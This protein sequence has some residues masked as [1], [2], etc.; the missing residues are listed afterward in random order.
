MS[1][2]V[3]APAE[4]SNDGHIQV[5]YGWQP[6]DYQMGAWAHFER[7]KAGARGVCVW[8]RRAGKDLFGVNLVAVKSTER[9]GLYWHLFPTYNQGRKIAWDGFTKTGRRFISHFPPALVESINNTEMRINL[10]TG[11]QYQVVGTEDP[12]RLVGANPVGCIFSEYSLQ[13][14]RAWDIIRPILAENEG[15]ALFIYTARGKNHGF[16]M[17]EGARK[18]IERDRAA[19]KESKWYAEVL[20]AGSGP[21]DT[22]RRD[23][24]PVISDE[25]IQEE[26]DAG[27]PEEL[28]AQEFKCSFEAPIVG[29]YYATQMARALEENRIGKV[30]WE[31]Q[32]KVNTAWDLGMGDAMSIVFFQEYGLETRIIDYYESSGEGL[33]HYIKVLRERDYVYGEHIAPWDIEVRELGTGKSRLEVA[34]SL[35]LN[36]RV[37]KQSSVSDGIEMVRNLI[38]TCWFDADKCDRLV[39][40]LRGYRKEYDEVRKVFKNNPLHDWTSHP[41]DAFRYLAMGRRKRPKNREKPQEAADSSYD[42]HSI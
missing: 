8:H 16:T 41:A 22:K 36:F 28:I 18:I 27:M 32:L 10:K 14:P 23:G 4:V 13:D 40:A 26:R 15:W 1:D 20:T 42:I 5:P 25:V 17:L 19:G 2:P 30:P 12:D 9:P 29:A 21:T 11:S 39:Q 24:T 33:A 35:G 31:P 34:K 38:P 37:L 3:T 6:R 7:V